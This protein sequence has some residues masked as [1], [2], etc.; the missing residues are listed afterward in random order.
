MA[1]DSEPQKFFFKA[2]QK[3]HFGEAKSL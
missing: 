2:P 1:S 3:L